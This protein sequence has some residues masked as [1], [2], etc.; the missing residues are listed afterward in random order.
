M[1][2]LGVRHAFV[3]HGETGR[4]SVKASGLDELTVTGASLI[5]EVRASRGT[6]RFTLEPE[7]LG[8]TRSPLATLGGGGS[9]EESASV[10]L[11][12]FCGDEHGPRRE[13]VVLNAAAAL[14]AGG[15]AADWQ[16]GLAR[17]ADAIDSGRTLKL[18]NELRTFR[19][20]EA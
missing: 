5:A 12:I 10:L 9:A 17:A 4:Q 19:R 13:I 8:L 16:E 2:L 7:D 20:G 6:R 14:V 1:G 3:V 18:L 15:I 11:A